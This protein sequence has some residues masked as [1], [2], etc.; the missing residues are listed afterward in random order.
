MSTPTSPVG[1]PGARS[2]SRYL[3]PL[4]LAVVVVV[5]LEAALGPV[6]LGATGRR[7]LLTH[8]QGEVGLTVADSG[9]EAAA[10]ADGA[11]SACPRDGRAG[12]CRRRPG[13]GGAD[14]G[15]G[16]RVHVAAGL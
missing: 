12:A 7:L 10:S 9:G 3:L 13:H 6:G 5:V 1:R 11:G 14:G 16:F 4:G 8:A 2:P 15:S